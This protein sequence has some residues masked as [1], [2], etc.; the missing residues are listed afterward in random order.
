RS[1]HYPLSLHDA[2]PISVVTRT[3]RSSVLEALAEDYVRTARAKGL[4]EWRVIQ[5][6]VLKNALIPESDLA[7]RAAGRPAATVAPP[8]D[9]RRSG[10]DTSELQSRGQPV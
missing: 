4:S 1:A 9:R 7:E 8:R 6:H 10:E 2:L 3:L 5:A